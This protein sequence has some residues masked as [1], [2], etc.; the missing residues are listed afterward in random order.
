MAR[1]GRRP[2]TRCTRARH[3]TIGIDELKIVPNGRLVSARSDAAGPGVSCSGNRCKG[4]V[5]RPRVRGSSSLR[6]PRGRTNDGSL[7]DRLVSSQPGAGATEARCPSVRRRAPASARRRGPQGARPAQASPAGTPGVRKGGRR[8]I[9]Q[10]A[11]PGAVRRSG[12]RRGRGLHPHRGVGLP[13]PR[14]RDFASGTAPRAR[15]CL[16]GRHAG[17]D[18]ALRRPVPGRP[19]RSG[20]RHGAQRTGGHRQLRRAT[21]GGGP[22]HDRGARRRLVGRQRPQGVGLPSGRLGWQRPRRDDDRLPHPWR[23]VSY[24]RRTRA[25]GRP[26]RGGRAL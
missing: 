3:S 5:R 7:H 10:G 20:C 14:L 4:P 22:A 11:H 21:A 18:P 24:R 26:H 25:P 23:G 13:Q 9:P 6:T 12:R 15:A 16:R 17:A 1:P 8:R 2:Q 19:R